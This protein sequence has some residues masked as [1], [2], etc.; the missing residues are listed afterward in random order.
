MRIIPTWTLGISL[1][2]TLTGI[3]DWFLHSEPLFNVNSFNAGVAY[4]RSQPSALQEHSLEDCKVYVADGMAEFNGYY[5]T[6]F[7]SGCY[8]ATY[9][10]Q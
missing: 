7:V 3:G 1:I 10:H 9:N 5:P 8:D 6:S 4:V 2:F